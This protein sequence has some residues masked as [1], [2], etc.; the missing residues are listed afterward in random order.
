MPL[1]LQAQKVLKLIAKLNIPPLPTMEPVKAREITAKYRGKPRRR[2]SPP[3]VEDKTIS[4]SAGDIPIRIY[5]P[6]SN[7]ATPAIAFFHGGGWV[8][9][10]LDAA[11]S[12]CWEISSQA[13]CVVVSVDYR[14][15]PEHK[16]P[17]ALEDGYAAIKWIVANADQL[18]INP[19]NIGV[20]GD[21]S[22]GNIAAAVALM[23]RDKGEIELFYQLLLYPVIHNDFNRASYLEYASGF[24]L[25]RDE[26]IWFWQL[27][28]NDET[29]AKNPYVSPI[30]A[31]DLSNLPPT[32]II[33]AE[34]D[35]LRDEAVAYAEKLQQAGVS[36]K[37]W[38]GKGTIHSFVGMAS[39]LDRGKEAI[40]FITTQ[41]RQ[42][43]W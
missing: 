32:L 40:A 11:D 22:G 21:S 33:V 20:A 7:I 13:C 36:V 16:F 25:T 15:A 28:L 14:L 8:L 34:C 2:K 38:E 30:L 12:I 41:L 1:D 26:M 10:D 29:E 19:N 42:A 9:G 4:T 27:Y 5:T 37:L 43:F 24:G 17:A 6:K 39:I 35:V 18:N 31:A 23:A 3:I